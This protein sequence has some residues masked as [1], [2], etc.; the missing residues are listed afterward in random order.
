MILLLSLFVGFS[1][2]AESFVTAET[3]VSV[4]ASKEQAKSASG[5]SGGPLFT[6]R[7]VALTLGS[8]AR[9]LKWMSVGLFFSYEA[10]NRES[11]LYSVDAGGVPAPLDCRSGQYRQVWLGPA[12]RFHWRQFFL[13][14]NYIAF[15]TR[16]DHAY[17]SLSGDG[18]N[19]GSFRT[20]PLKAW[21]FFPGVGIPL[22]DDLELLIKLEYRYV[23]YDERSGKLPGGQLYGNQSIRP[24]IALSMNLD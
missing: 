7:Q 21:V 14:A 16:K 6:D 9:F 12:L 2:H 23:Y 4:L 5:A 3:G 10:G 1:A 17:S 15:G 24:Q 8:H 19:Q 11:C 13:D 20:H 18:T 22:T